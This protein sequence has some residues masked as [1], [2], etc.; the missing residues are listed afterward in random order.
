MYSYPTTL[1]N[2][3][4]PAHLQTQ[5]SEICKYRHISRTRLILDFLETTVKQWKPFLEE[6]RKLQVSSAYKHPDEPSDKDA[7][8]GFFG[9]DER[10]P[11]DAS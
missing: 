9:S 4:I 11:S 10:E 1:A 5:L 8:V 6:H 7:P 2:F 3:R